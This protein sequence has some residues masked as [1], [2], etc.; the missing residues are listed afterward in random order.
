MKLQPRRPQ[1]LAKPSSAPSL[2]GMRIFFR[3]DCVYDFG[4]GQASLP[5]HGYSYL[6]RYIWVAVLVAATHPQYAAFFLAAMGATVPCRL[7]LIGLVL[8]VSPFYPPFFRVVL[9]KVFSN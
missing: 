9:T 1:Q 5:A 6:C 8:I 4:S 2:L 7:L 3:G